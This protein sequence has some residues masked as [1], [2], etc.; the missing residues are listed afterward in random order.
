MHDMSTP[1]P[2]A[3]SAQMLEVPLLGVGTVLR[4]ERDAWLLVKAMVRIKLV[5][6]PPPRSRS[7]AEN[8]WRSFGGESTVGLPLG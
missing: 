4:L 1:P 2:T 5:P 3:V 7:C 6:P 8:I